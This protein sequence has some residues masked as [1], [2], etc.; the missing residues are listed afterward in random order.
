MTWGLVITKP[1]VRNLDE[2]PR[3][4]VEHINAAFEE[5]R[6]DPYGGDIKFLKGTKRTLRRRVGSWRILFDVNADQ[7]IVV[8]LGVF[9]R[10][11]NTY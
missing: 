11:S 8:I 9:R 3:A 10:S 4:D 6:A 1:A 2:V 5:M 7:R